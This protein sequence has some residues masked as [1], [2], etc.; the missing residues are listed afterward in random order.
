MRP[1]LLASALVLGCGSQALTPSG[2]AP[3]SAAPS[4]DGGSVAPSPDAGTVMV[5]EDAGSPRDAGQPAPTDAGLVEPALKIELQPGAACAEWLPATAPSAAQPPPGA[6][7]ALFTDGLSDLAA[8]EVHRDVYGDVPQIHFPAD[9]GI[10]QATIDQNVTATSGGFLYTATQYGP[11]M[12]CRT[13]LRSWPS[14]GGLFIGDGYP[15]HGS[16]SYQVRPQGGVYASC[17]SSYP[18]T[19]GGALSLQQRDEAL[20]LTSETM[21][22]GPR[23]VAVDRLDRLVESGDAGVRWIDGQ[24]APLSGFFGAVAEGAFPLIG[25]GLLTTDDRVIPSGETQVTPAPDW[26]RGQAAGAF[27]VLAGRAY[28][29]TDASCTAR[30]YSA[31]GELCG[32][33]AFQGCSAPPRFGADGSAIVALPGGAWRLWTRLLR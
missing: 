18:F 2:A 26:L 31:G 23:I 19:G 33:L 4:P 7:T 16:C 3:A 10:A 32:Q 13:L 14:G 6:W 21:G 8:V 11:C 1:L 28:A 17:E 25:G 30:I 5:S 22:I 20:H 24:G 29:F 12:V 27:V 15:W 9:G